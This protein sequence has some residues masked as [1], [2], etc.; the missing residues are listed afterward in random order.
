MNKVDKIQEKI[1]EIINEVMENAIS[2]NQI[3]DD[4]AQLGMDSIT[5]IRIVVILEETFNIEMP[6]EYLIMSE[7]NTIAK[8]TKLIFDTL[9]VIIK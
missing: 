8:I 3:N 1:L 4:L 7:M 5:F 9:N 6:D 2:S